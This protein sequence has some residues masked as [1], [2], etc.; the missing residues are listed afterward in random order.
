MDG[1]RAAL[2]YIHEY[3]ALP[4]WLESKEDQNSVGPSG[5]DE[6]VVERLQTEVRQWAIQGAGRMV[7]GEEKPLAVLDGFLLF[8]ESVKGVRTSIDIKILLR[9]SYAK[10]KERRESRSGYVTLEGFWE[11]PPGYV[12]MVVWPNYMEEHGFLFEGGNVEGTVDEKVI[13]QLGLKVCPGQGDWGMEKVLEW[14]VE[15]VKVELEGRVG[16]DQ[17]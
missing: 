9:A 14:A 15:T 4:H 3:G 10:A 2:K 7:L 8:G 5:V 17:A 12:D 11:D 13:D 6:A 16:S 1:M